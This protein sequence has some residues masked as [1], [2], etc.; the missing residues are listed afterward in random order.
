MSAVIGD[1][2]RVLRMKE[3]FTA[4]DGQKVC[5]SLQDK[6]MTVRAVDELGNIT[7]IGGYAVIFRN[8]FTCWASYRCPELNQNLL[9]WSKE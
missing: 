4:S 3:S 1:R 8:N 5:G 2:V 7:M 6:A 9:I